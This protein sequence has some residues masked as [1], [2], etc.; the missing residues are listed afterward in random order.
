[1][2]KINTHGGGCN[3]TKLGLHFE[4]STD[5]PDVLFDA[6]YNLTCL[7]CAGS[8]LNGYKVANSMGQHLGIATRKQRFYKDFLEPHGVDWR[9]RIS[10]QLFPDDV[11]INDISK[12][13]YIIEKKFQSQAGSVDEK[14]QTCDFK[15]EQYEKLCAGTGYSVKYTYVANEWFYKHEYDDVHDYINRSGC[16]I[17]CNEIP[18]S[19][20]GI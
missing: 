5:L 11:F 4:Q 20:L 17:F 10:K 8:V 1:M 16:Y 18:L 2:S 15:R 9:T 13:V 12:T 7:P 6:G 3:T 14:L 19:F